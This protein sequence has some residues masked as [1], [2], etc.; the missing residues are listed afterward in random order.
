MSDWRTRR[1]KSFAQ[2]GARRRREMGADGQRRVAVRRTQ[3]QPD[4]QT[5]GGYEH[6]ALTTPP[7]ESSWTLA[8]AGAGHGLDWGHGGEVQTSAR[9][10]TWSSRRRLLDQPAATGPDRLPTVMN[11]WA[12]PTR[13][14]NPSS[15]PTT[16]AWLHRT[17]STGTRR[18]DDRHVAGR[19]LGTGR[20]RGHPLLQAI[21]G[22]G[23]RPGAGPTVTATQTWTGLL[24]GLV[25][26][27]GNAYYGCVTPA[28]GLG[29]EPIHPGRGGPPPAARA[30][31][32]A[33]CDAPLRP[34]PSTGRRSRCPKMRGG[35]GRR[36]DPGGSPP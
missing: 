18:R 2:D 24:R 3:A 22:E 14:A 5:G 31:P 25:A 12:I 28:V 17:R 9:T 10:T 34:S 33:P 7:V 4:R 32:T 20:K 13:T 8:D 27:D 19:G 26:E 30:T 16:S 21:S 23:E 11:A 6:T 15:S 36:P 1:S 29:D 35:Q